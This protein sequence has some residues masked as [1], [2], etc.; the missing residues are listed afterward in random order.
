MCGIFGVICSGE[1]RA[2]IAR[3]LAVALLRHSETRGREAVGLAVHDGTRIEVLKQGGSVSD[4]LDNPK[5]HA[6][7]AGALE[8]KKQSGD[9]KALAITGHSRLATNGAQSNSDNNQ[10]VI[11]RGSVTLH[12]GIIVNDR[13]LAERHSIT[14]QSELDSEVLARLLRKQLDT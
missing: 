10:P 3:D 13:Q 4:F 9:R 1:S 14:L 11:T 6:L 7:L 2:D 8:R 12:N 5:L